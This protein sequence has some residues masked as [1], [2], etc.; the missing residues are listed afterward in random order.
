MGSVLLAVI[1]FLF[2]DTEE[3]QDE[4]DGVQPPSSPMISN[5]SQQSR[6]R[7]KNVKLAIHFLCAF[8]ILMSIIAF[9]TW[10]YLSVYMV[11]VISIL[12]SFAFVIYHFEKSIYPVVIEDSL[13]GNG[14]ALDVLYNHL[15]DVE[16]HEDED[17]QNPEM[18]LKEINSPYIYH[19]K[20]SSAT[21]KSQTMI[22]WCLNRTLKVHYYLVHRVWKSIKSHRL[23]YALSG[24]II[25]LICLVIPLTME[26]TCICSHPMHVNTRFSRRFMESFCG[27]GTVCF[28]YLTLPEDGSNSMILQYHSRDK[29]AKS[30]I[31]L[32]NSKNG[33]SNI[34]H[35]G[36]VQSM[37][38]VILDEPR[39]VSYIELVSLQPDSV[40]QFQVF[41][42][43]DKKQT[44]QSQVYSFQTLSQSPDKEVL[45]ATGGDIQLNSDSEDLG[46]QVQKLK[47]DVVA[48]GGDIAYEDGISSC[49]RRWDEKL[50]YFQK[51]FTW[52][53]TSTNSTRLIPLL[54]AIGNH[55][56]G[57]FF[58][59][60]KQIPF[61]QRYFIFK[62]GDIN[63]PVNK[64]MTYHIHKLSSHSSI[65]SLD[66][67][68][69]NTWDE[70][71]VW[72]D[73]KWSSADYI[74][75]RK[76]ALY[77]T[78]IYPGYSDLENKYSLSGRNDIEPVF[79]KY[80]VPVVFENHEHIFKRSKSIYNSDIAP[81]SDNSTT[82]LGTVYV[83]G[84]SYG[85]ASSSK[86][87]DSINLPWWLEKRSRDNHV[88]IAQMSVISVTT[89]AILPNGD[90]LDTFKIKF[91]TS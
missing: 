33:T 23:P 69:V 44:I 90:T 74:N 49:Y 62:L 29:P 60:Y 22:Q 14:I 52:S 12:Y 18:M 4:N 67:C 34:L 65:V 42:E 2:L 88:W 91:K 58:Q 57:G 30:Y 38:D 50:N 54:F 87:V 6:N 36:S 66:S 25:L 26:G 68:V 85:I 43:T 86:S 73:T 70:Q 83:G 56:A 78:P 63:L 41:I 84:G 55:E 5:P 77:H 31:A 21:V 81:D 71:S 89:T 20:P 3:D 10:D 79:N 61:Y 45:L 8:G 9:S 19:K 46:K 35:V 37:Q 1:N 39:F 16:H 59:S 80:Q 17:S 15:E 28:T 47:P 32:T 64:R 27:A 24:V 13:A 53:D 40:Y 7:I 72:L 75:T 51:Y 48:F 76:Y 11:I 82:K